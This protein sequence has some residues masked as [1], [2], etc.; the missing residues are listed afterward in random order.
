MKSVFITG[1]TSGIG[2]ILAEICLE[3]GYSVYATGRNKQALTDLSKLG[4]TSIE[5]DLN[6]IEE[7][8]KLSKNLPKVDVAVL[9]AG[10]GY[11]QAAT[12]L[13]DEEI[14]DMININ[15]KAPIILSRYIAKNMMEERKGHIIFI[16]SQAGKVPECI[17]INKTCNNR[18]CEWTSDGIKGS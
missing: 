5:V 11:F 18:F 8:K 9:N 6:N 1:A 16:G 15:V 2:R 17:R 14:S 12:D 4:A 10:V 3:K 13:S 7:I